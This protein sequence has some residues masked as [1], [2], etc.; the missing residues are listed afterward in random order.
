MS[1]MLERL[2]KKRAEIEKKQKV[3]AQQVSLPFSNLNNNF[4]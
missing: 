3:L 1:A 4:K 2:E